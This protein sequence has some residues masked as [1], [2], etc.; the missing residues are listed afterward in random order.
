MMEAIMFQT[1]LDPMEVFEVQNLQSGQELQPQQT[2]KKWLK[3]PVF[4]L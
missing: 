4:C 1:I 2:H 3:S